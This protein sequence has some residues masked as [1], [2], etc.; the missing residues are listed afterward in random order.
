MILVLPK[1]FLRTVIKLC[2]IACL[3]SGAAFGAEPSSTEPVR[4]CEILEN[5]TLFAGK[6]VLLVGRYSYR[7]KG[8][9]LGE[10]VC[11]S[12]QNEKASALEV[13]YDV[14]TA[15]KTPDNFSVDAAALKRKLAAVKESTS[16]GK[17]RFGSQEYDRWALA[18]GRIEITAADSPEP[19]ESLKKAEF[20]TP[21]RLV[22]R[23]AGLVIF[24]TE[25]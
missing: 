22:C 19:G 12:G 14:K 24:L 3:L 7:E 16:L 6:T 15:P 11:G 4:I 2:G 5:P 18:Y 9:F 21:G 20:R 1:L 8:L 10:A 25:P 23:G 13:V 17:F